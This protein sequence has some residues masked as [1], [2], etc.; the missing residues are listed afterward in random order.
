MHVV[1]EKDSY[2]RPSNR[3]ERHKE[4]VAMSAP[5]PTFCWAWFWF[6]CVFLSYDKESMPE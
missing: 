2:D 1:G 4:T 3:R 5:L 6:R